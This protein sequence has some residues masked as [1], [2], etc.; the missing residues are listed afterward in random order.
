[1][2]YAITCLLGCRLFN[3]PIGFTLAGWSP[4]TSQSKKCSAWLGLCLWF[5]FP[6]LQGFPSNLFL[7]LAKSYIFLKNQ[8][9]DLLLWEMF[10]CLFA[11]MAV[12]S[13]SAYYYNFYIVVTLCWAHKMLDYSFRGCKSARKLRLPFYAHSFLVFHSYQRISE[14][15]SSEQLL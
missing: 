13:H 6:L 8:F 12:F 3:G 11:N 5:W 9:R 14:C 7:W 1:M 10:S 2:T 15:H 4:V